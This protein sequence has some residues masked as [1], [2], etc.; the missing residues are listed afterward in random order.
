LLN[1]KPFW[2]KQVES[3]TNLRNFSP[4]A[5]GLAMPSTL[6]DFDVP[7]ELAV[8]PNPYGMTHSLKLT[9]I[10]IVNFCFELWQPLPDQPLL[11]QEAMLLKGDCLRVEEICALLVEAM[12]AQM[13][14]LD[15][16]ITETLHQWRQVRQKLASSFDAIAV[17]STLS[18]ETSATNEFLREHASLHAADQYLVFLKFVELETGYQ[19]EALPYQLSF[20]Q[21]G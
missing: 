8:A 4:I 9:T 18:A 20:A 1:N 6:M 11:P 12:G 7:Y 10:T 2:W 3:I 21:V 5:P 13:R 19:V 16:E 17:H 15:N 14:D